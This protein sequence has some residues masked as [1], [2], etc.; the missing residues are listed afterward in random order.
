M[1][2]SLQRGSLRVVIVGVTAVAILALSALLNTGD[3]YYAHLFFIVIGSALTWRHYIVWRRRRDQSG[4]ELIGTDREVEGL[5][6]D[7]R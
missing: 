3:T 2:D 1:F 6:P 7:G 4:L 5:Y